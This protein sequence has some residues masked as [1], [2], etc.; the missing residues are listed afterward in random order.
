MQEHLIAYEAG[1][2]VP[3]MD[4]HL[5]VNAA[6]FYYD[7]TNKQVRSRI[8][9]PSFG[10][11]EKMLNLPK[12]HIEGIEGEIV[13]RPVEGLTLSASGVYLKSKVD[14]SF[15]VAGYNQQGYTGD[16]TGSQLPFTPKFS[17]VADVDYGFNVGGQLKA[18]LGGSVT[19]H[20]KSNATF[21][22]ATLL[23][24][25]YDL[26]AYAL[27]DL[28]AGI[29]APDDTWRVSIYGH[30]ITNTLVV[31]T[32]F[33]GGDTTWRQVAEPTTYGVT[34]SFKIR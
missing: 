25:V 28:R 33:T 7:Y 21:G 11:L 6:A 30:N 13:A 8:L 19:Y 4:H 14:T 34:V 20:G 12:S 2:K 26:K 15:I 10:L 9:D 3:L 18:S 23:N 17:G 5:Q 22:T 32:I 16:F 1:F 31:N 27:L 24:D 29:G